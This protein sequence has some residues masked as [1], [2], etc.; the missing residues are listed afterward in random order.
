QF[1]RHV[2]HRLLDARLGLF[3]GC[4]PKS[5][6]RRP[7]AA[8]VLLNEIQAFDG[9]KQLGIA[10]V[11]DFQK[12]LNVSRGSR[13]GTADGSELLEPDELADPVIDMDDQVPDLE[14]S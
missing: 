13:N 9:H 14:V 1:L 8:R 2:T 5:V 12:L 10:G 6:E 4:S 7:R 11:T 3:P